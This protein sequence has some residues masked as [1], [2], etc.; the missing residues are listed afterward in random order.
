MNPANALTLS[1]WVNPAKLSST[2]MV[3][4]KYQPG[5]IQ[6]FIR[7]QSGGTVRFNLNAGGT[8]AGVDSNAMITANAWHHIAGTYD[9]T[10]IRLYVDGVLDSFASKTGAMT[11]NGSNFP[12]QIGSDWLPN[13]PRRRDGRPCVTTCHRVSYCV[14]RAL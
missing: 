10:Q 12:S 8:V 7:I 5:L 1:V 2:Q 4:A 11:D 13:M 14:T 6:Y 3:V 9:G